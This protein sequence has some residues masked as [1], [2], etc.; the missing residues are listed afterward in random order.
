MIESR[1][2]DCRKYRASSELLVVLSNNV[3]R[4]VRFAVKHRDWGSATLT[5]QLV[6]ALRAH[7]VDAEVVGLEDESLRAITDSVVVFVK[8]FDPAVLERAKD[9]GNRLVWKTVD[10]FAH[11]DVE[12]RATAVDMLIKRFR[13]RTRLFDGAIFPNRRAQKDFSLLF[14]RRAVHTAL[15]SHADSRWKRNCADE[16]SLAYIGLKMNVAERFLEL[17]GMH[18]VETKGEA[19]FEQARP[20]S[21]HFSVREEGSR[22]FFYKPNTKLVVAAASGANIVLSKD[23]AHLETLDP[24]YPYFTD[25]DPNSVE[26]AVAFARET[27]GGRE[28]REGLDMLADV[29]D[30]TSPSRIALGYIEYFRM[31]S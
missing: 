20:F 19:F 6:D 10:V 11:V 29:R 13:H 18:Y 25:T 12:Y 4:P 30:R 31:L 21:C 14:D 1:K 23:P 26:Q 9:N 2:F 3:T 15:S 28:W 5:F 7:G 17:D 16:F 22:S 24:D 8:F 27:F